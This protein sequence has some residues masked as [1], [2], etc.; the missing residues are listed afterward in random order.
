[1]KTIAFSFLFVA[2]ASDAAI[3]QSDSSDHAY[4]G[5]KVA[6]G[7]SDATTF[8]GP[9]IG[10]KVNSAYR[11]ASASSTIPTI[12]IPAGNYTY[13]TDMVFGGPVTLR[14][15]PGT[16]LNYAGT[17]Y[18]VKLGPDGLTVSNYNPLP[19]TVNGCQFT[20]GARA[21]VGIFVNE[22]V[23]KSYVDEV[24]FMRF[25]GTSTW[26][27]WYQGSNWDARVDKLYV[28]LGN[29]NGIYQ[30]AADPANPVNGDYGQS[31]LYVLNSHI[32][33]SGQGIYLNGFNSIVDNTNLSMANGPSIQL[34]GWANGAV[35]QNVYMERTAGSAP[36][37]AY[38]DGAN[39]PRAK[40]LISLVSVKGIYCNPHNK[41]FHT[42]AGVIAPTTGTSRISNWTL[43]SVVASSDTLPGTPLV[44]QNDLNGQSGNTATSVFGPAPL[45][46]TGRNIEAWSGLAG[47]A[48]AP[49]RQ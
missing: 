3:A 32:Q 14:C 20:G 36:C 35:L 19:Y 2:L 22:F 38:G 48:G 27:L 41:D 46:T 40:N 12:Y 43:E 29:T 26:A 10:A 34:G 23:V 25:G 6:G 1:M 49:P 39:S 31:H 47:D 9:D 17:N 45:H 37:V 44:V 13:S 30:N 4:T 28:W 21:V 5:F 15:E 24:M 18:A 33:G 7:Q 42:S 8:P 16:V 11:V